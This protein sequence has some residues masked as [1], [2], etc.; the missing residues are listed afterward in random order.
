MSRRRL[1][2]RAALTLALVA[3]AAAPASALAAGPEPV[4]PEDEE[5]ARELFEN[6]R[7]LFKEGHYEEA[8]LAWQASWDT[9][10]HPL[11]L[12]NI[13]SALERLERWEEARDTLNRYRAYAPADEREALETRIFALERRIELDAE[14]PA[15]GTSDVGGDP[16]DGS[17]DIDDGTSIDGPA[18]SGG[19]PVVRTGPSRAVPIT[20]FSVGAA[21]GAAG[22]VF[23]LRADSARLEALALCTGNSPYTCDVGA[24]PWLRQDRISSAVADVGFV[25]GVAGAAG[26]I[27]TWLSASRSADRA[28]A[29]SLDLSPGVPGAPAGLVVSGRF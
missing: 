5:R 16:D 27:A 12:Y 26:G 20:L 15:D 9:T 21:G 13:A 25:I 6:G 14:P 29:V 7:L 3:S 2:R 23:A 17:S 19:A 11:L 4:S 22:L 8:I 18:T 1:W 28:E 10:Q 24:E